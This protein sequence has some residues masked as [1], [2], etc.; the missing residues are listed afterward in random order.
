MT[1][2]GMVLGPPPTPPVEAIAPTAPAAAPRY[3]TIDQKAIG[4]ND[5][6]VA[7]S[8][9]ADGDLT[10]TDIQ[11]MA[12]A[13]KKHLVRVFVYQAGQVVGTD[14]PAMAWEFTTAEGVKR[15]Y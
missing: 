11:A 13:T 12:T 7:I 15:L 4:R 9:R 3:Q 6:G 2:L 5:F 1:I 8:V 10:A 14:K